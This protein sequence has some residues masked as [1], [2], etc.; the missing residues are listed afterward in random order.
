MEK[1]LLN[2]T[3]NPDDIKEK[4]DD[5]TI[6]Y[7]YNGQGD[8]IG[9]E[10]N[11]KIY[12]Y[13]RNVL[14]DVIRILDDKGN[15]VSSYA[16]DAL[17]NTVK[18]TG[19]KNIANLNPLRYRSYYFDV[20]T[21]LYYLNNRYY[22]CKTGRF[23]SQDMNFDTDN[24]IFGY[25]L[26]TYCANDYINYRDDLGN[27]KIGWNKLG[28]YDTKAKIFYYSQEAP[29]KYFGYCDFYDH[30]SKY[31]LMQL[32]T[33]KAEFKY[34]KETWRIQLW[35][36]VYGK[37]GNY[38][39]SVG[40]EIGIYKKVN[41]YIRVFKC[42]TNDKMMMQFT[43]Y[44]GEKKL[45]RR[46]GKAWWLTGFKYISKTKGYN[47]LKMKNISITLKNKTMA[48]SFKNT[49]ANKKNIV[50]TNKKSSSKNVKFTWK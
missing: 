50:L 1:A 6:W 31:V 32:K 26:Y 33:V 13:E 3:Q 45:F 41:P 35:R 47:N 11:N 8:L 42:A 7:I 28:Y 16:Y 9:A 30:A 43:L 10:I 2:V 14:G 44:N 36:G 4:N 18:I 37:I 48:Q 5:I 34:K 49:L 29:Q 25:N 22:D 38:K 46:K 24:T 20:E 21:G 23:I 15:V 40:G 17:G 12:Y 39:L 27:F 19:D